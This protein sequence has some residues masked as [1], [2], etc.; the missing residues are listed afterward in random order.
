MQSGLTGSH[1]VCWSP[2]RPTTSDLGSEEDSAPRP[3][4]CTMASRIGLRLQLM[5]DQ[6][7]QEEQREREQQQQ[8]AMHY[9]QQRMPA[10]QTPAINTPVH[11]QSPMQ[12]PVEVLKVQTHLENPTKYHIQQSQRQQV[13]QYLSTTFASKQTL[14]AVSGVQPSPPP[15]V[16]SPHMRPDL[17]VNTSAG[18]STPNSPMA[19]LNISANPEREM[20]DVIDDI[21]SLESS[22]NDDILAYIDPVQMSNT[23]PL[24]SSHL[25]VYTGPGMAGPTIGMTSNSCPANLAIKREMSDAEARALAKERQ[26]KDNHNQIERR[27]RFN[28]NDRIKELGTMIPKTNDLDVRWNKGTILKASVDYIKRM[29]KDMHRSREVETNLK[30]M[31]MTNKQLWVR[32]QELEMQARV[33]GLASSSPSGLGGVEML[34]PL[35]KQESSLEDKASLE[36]FQQHQQQQHQQQQ[37]LSHPEQQYSQHLDFTQTLELCDSAAGFHDPLSHFTDLT[38]T[39]PHKNDYMLM[40]DALSPLGGD[41][42]LSAMSPD[43]SVVSSRRSSFSMEDSDV[44]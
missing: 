27:R 37:Q 1:S 39:S 18:N 15:P 20:D 35:I 44:Q 13:K 38:F 30:R 7:Q 3:V 10:P 2:D 8:A 42:L 4:S 16:P 33:H 29:Q 12:V 14:Q 22:Y 26:K 17:L 32:I 24:S 9:M 21:I 5:R 36:A 31:E 41:P 11:F 43:P 6:L 19:L 25:D 28:I 23:L 40:E 34:G